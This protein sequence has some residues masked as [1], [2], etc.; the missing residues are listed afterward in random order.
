MLNKIDG[1]ISRFNETRA[2]AKAP[3]AV[4]PLS[5]LL[6]DP[7]YKPNVFFLKYRC[8]SPRVG[9]VVQ[10]GMLITFPSSNDF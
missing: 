6:L 10:F 4:S 9:I 5:P 1:K 8:H 7:I 3:N 2:Q